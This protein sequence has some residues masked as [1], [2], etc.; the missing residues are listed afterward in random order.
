[1]H[2]CTRNA[3]SGFTLVE[4]LVVIAIIGILAAL[5]LPALASGRRMARKTECKSNLRQLGF[6]LSMYADDYEMYPYLSLRPGIEI[7]VHDEKL[8]R[9]PDD[10]VEREDTYSLCYRGGHP[11]SLGNDLEIILCPC[12]NGPPFGVF[13]DGRVADV[14]RLKGTKGILLTGH[15]GDPN[16]PPI[17]YPYTNPGPIQQIYYNAGG[18][19]NFCQVQNGTITAIYGGGSPTFIG[20]APYTDPD[21]A[22]GSDIYN[23]ATE[24]V[25]VQFDLFGP[26]A[27]FMGG[28]SWPRIDAC[29]HSPGELSPYSGYPVEQYYADG[30]DYEP[31]NTDKSFKLLL[32][33]KPKRYV[34]HGYK[35]R[36]SWSGPPSG[37]PALGAGWGD[38]VGYLIE[39]ET[40][41]V[42][43]FWFW[44][45]GW[46][47]Q[48]WIRLR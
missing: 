28:D 46:P 45:K 39:T 4:L 40:A 33:A 14:P 12:H 35:Y 17:A 34:N 32:H 41:R 29:W 23:H 16:G 15:L 42:T 10:P 20:S 5:L 11:I 1:M 43:E 36:A 48:P 47:S 44:D 18:A 19:T 9:C 25:N 24:A 3:G 37:Y 21:P 6:A 2:R 26:S 8:F 31:R 7:F 27:R 38:H 22:V 30:P 13:G